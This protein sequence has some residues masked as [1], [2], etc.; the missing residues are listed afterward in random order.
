MLTDSL[1]EVGRLLPQDVGNYRG[2]I[3]T[4]QSLSQ[5]ARDGAVFIND[6]LGL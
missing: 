1:T 3:L 2:L 4:M 6:L 5:P